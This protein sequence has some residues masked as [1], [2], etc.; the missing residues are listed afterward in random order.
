MKKSIL[1][2]LG[3]VMVAAFLGMTGCKPESGS[4]QSESSETSSE[5]APLPPEDEHVDLTYP[6]Q[7]SEIIEISDAEFRQQ[8]L[9]NTGSFL[10]YEDARLALGEYLYD[11]LRAHNHMT[12]DEFSAVIGAIGTFFNMYERENGYRYKP[13]YNIIYAI[14]YTNPD[15]LYSTIKEVQDDKVAWGYA[16]NLL[17][18]WDYSS[19][20][21]NADYVADG[22]SSVHEIAEEEKLLLA[23]NPYAMDGYS[24]LLDIEAFINDEVGPVAVRFAH[25]ACRSMIRNLTETEIGLVIYNTVLD[26]YRDSQE[27]IEVQDAVLANCL[28]FVHHM[29]AWLSEFD[30]NAAT[31]S[32][33]YPLF[34]GLY[35][36]IYSYENDFDGAFFVE[37]DWF[38]EMRNAFIDLLEGCNPEGF[39][40]IVKFLG[41]LASNMTEEQLDMFFVDEPEDF[42]GQ[43]LI[44]LYNEQYGLLTADDKA[45]LNDFWASLGV[46]FDRFIERLKEAALDPESLEPLPTRGDDEEEEEKTIFDVIFEEEITDKIGENF[47][48]GEPDYYCVDRSGD[49]VLTVKEGTNFTQTNFEDY[50]HCK[51][52]PRIGALPEVLFA[53][54][55]KSYSYY[56]SDL[57]KNGRRYSTCSITIT[58]PPKISTMPPE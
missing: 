19:D 16:I 17:K 4:S 11:F 9:N 54:G 53:S 23:A 14:A 44:D 37:A 28:S 29:G 56:L 20:Y 6:L 57:A 41:M 46:D 8:A 24:S 32:R 36:S 42:D 22:R 27:A 10:F 34:N 50:L 18:F 5:P 2:K 12:L 58:A 49:N 52:T 43:L 47:A 31:Y 35:L 30:V 1:T 39:R 15:R 3:L 7:Q 21:I 38:E 48:F 40:I 55:D 26:D 25:R 45:N 51:S 13:V 33:L